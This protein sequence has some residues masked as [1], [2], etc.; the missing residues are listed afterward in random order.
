MSPLGELWLPLHRQSAC[1]HQNSSLPHA[2]YL[3]IHWVLSGSSGGTRHVVLLVLGSEVFSD[4]ADG[5]TV[6]H[7]NVS[8]KHYVPPMNASVYSQASNSH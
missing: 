3:T 2:Y 1:R 5:C 6:W 4:G 8:F 7:L